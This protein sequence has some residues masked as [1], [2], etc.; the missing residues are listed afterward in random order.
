METGKR[1]IWFDIGRICLGVTFLYN[2]ID[3]WSNM[4]T[5]DKVV[6]TFIGYPPF[7]VFVLALVWAVTGV[8]LIIN[9]CSRLMG[10]I[11]AACMMFILC[12]STYRGFAYQAGFEFMA[13][14]FC[15]W[16]CMIGGSLMAAS[17]GS[18]WFTD[19]KTCEESL[20]LFYAGRIMIGV[21]FWTAGWLHLSHI[22]GDS[23]ALGHFPNPKLWVVLSGFGWLAC[24]FAFWTNILS[25]LACLGAI[26]LV[27]VITFMINIHGYLLAKG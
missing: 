18:W 24:A 8:S 27:T 5:L 3:Y 25:R 4:A 9:V 26:L 16:F 21:F 20:D 6:P 11:A 23:H 22:A 2:A 7:W 15:G 12:T 10:V 1:F 14:K 17:R 19:K 13:L